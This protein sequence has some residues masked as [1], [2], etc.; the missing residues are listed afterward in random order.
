MGINSLPSLEDYWKEDKV[1]HY[2]PV[3][4]KI[5]RARFR[6]I[7]RYT[8]YVDNSTLSLPGSPGYDR[9]GKVRPLINF[10][11]TQFRIINTPGRELVVDE[12]MIMFLGR[13]SLKQYI[14]MPMKPIKRQIKVCFLFLYQLDHMH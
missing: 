6:E 4:D 10:L 2:R 3:A 13:S 1:Y 5:P 9:L 14:Y 11:Q 7:S 12:A 8:H